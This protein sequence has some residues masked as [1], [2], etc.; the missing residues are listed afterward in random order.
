M[1]TKT[2]IISQSHYALRINQE[3][4]QIITDSEL[5]KN[6]EQ[7][8]F[9][10]VRFFDDNSTYILSTL[11]EL[12]YHH[13]QEEFL[14]APVV[15]EKLQKEKFHYLVMPDLEDGFSQAAYD[16]KVHFNVS[17]PIYL[18]E[19]YENYFDLYV[20][21]LKEGN[22]S[23]IN[24]YLNNMDTLEKFKSHFKEKSAHLIKTSNENRIQFPAHLRPNFG[25]MG[26]PKSEDII[27]C[28]RF[29]KYQE[30]LTTRELETLQLLGRGMTA[31]EAAKKLKLSHRTIEYYLNMVKGKLEIKKKS[32]L[33]TFCHEIGLI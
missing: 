19:R 27:S 4:N 29:K 2:P 33:I 8:Y 32:E 25:G 3:V 14:A 30:S 12:V 11:G 16:Y 7:A 15:P 10:Y 5:N 18:F 13:L 9:A 31:K 22:A 23:S 1:S 17:H 28:P 24:T 20:Y 21:C 26:K 6:L